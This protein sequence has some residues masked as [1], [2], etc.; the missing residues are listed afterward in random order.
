MRV[1]ELLTAR[2][3]H[4]LSGPIAAVGNGVEL[5]GEDD[6]DFAREALTLSKT[7][8]G[9]PPI[10]CNFIASPMASER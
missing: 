7:A 10:G 3:C 1:L 5:L 9:A 6:P 4:E 8:R 2:L